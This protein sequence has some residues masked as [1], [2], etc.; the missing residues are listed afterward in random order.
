MIIVFG[1]ISV[2]LRF[3]VE[4]L[5]GSNETVS[6][7]DSAYAPGGKG[8]NQALAAARSGAKVTLVGR[9]GVDR[10]GEEI[11]ER[12]RNEGITTSGAAH[13]LSPTGTITTITDMQGLSQTIISSGANSHLSA[14][15]LPAK[16]LNDKALVLLQTDIGA[17]ENA[18]VLTNAKRAGAS[19]MMNLA[20]SIELTQKALDHL[21]YLVV[22]QEQ[23]RQLAQ[24]LGLNVENSALKMA[25]GLAKQG[26]LNC[27]IT[28]GARGGKAV[29]KDGCGWSVEALPIDKVIDHSG[30]EDSYSGT[31][32]ACLQ[33]GLP[34]PRAMKRASIAA[35]LTC[36]KKGAQTA[37]PTL[38]EIDKRINDIADPQQHE[39]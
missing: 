11:L 16:I 13:E 36:T 34:L 35:S 30:A 20:P 33:A 5:P 38:D 29:T 3:N 4:E 26:N 10:F 1:A 21:D 37:F 17:E 31:L 22:N 8:A 23:A 39:L 2:D 9:T 27:I 15:Q 14:S 18:A 19:T 25:Q 6:A 12:L 7:L 24:K 28:I 32:A